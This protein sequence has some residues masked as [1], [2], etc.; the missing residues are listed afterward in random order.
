[1]RAKPV[2][3]RGRARPLGGEILN[4]LGLLATLALVLACG[5]GMTAALPNLA[6]PWLASA[7]YA[8]PA[9]FAFVAWWW[10]AQRL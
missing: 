8:A 3:A 4:I 1:M 5:A 10:I 9:A 2:G 7:A 6:D